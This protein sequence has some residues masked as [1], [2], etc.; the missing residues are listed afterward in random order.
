MGYIIHMTPE[1]IANN[2]QYQKWIESFGPNCLNLMVNESGEALPCTEGIYRQQRM[3]NEVCPDLFPKIF[4]HDFTGT[5]TQEVEVPSTNLTEAKPLAKY[6]MRTTKAATGNDAIGVSLEESELTERI[7]EESSLSS[8]LNDFKKKVKTLDT[9]GGEYPIVSFLGTG[10]AVPSKYRNVSGHLLQLNPT[11]SVLIDCGE[12]TYG[13]L[14]VLH[15]PDRIE[16]TLMGLS[17]IFVTHAH[18]DHIGGIMTIIERRRE[19]FESKD[20]KYK[21][22]VLACNYNVR[23]MLTMYRSNFHNLD[24]YLS[25]VEI[26]LYVTKSEDFSNYSKEDLVS[27]ITENLPK[28]LYSPESWN[29]KKVQAAQVHHTRMANGFIFD[30]NCGKR[31]VFSGD[32]MPCKLLA[33]TGKDADLL[34]HEATFE[35]GHENDA[36]RKKH[37]TIGQAIGVAKTMN[38]KHLILSHFSARYPRMTYISDLM[39]S[40]G[41]VGVAFDNMVVPF[42]KH[43]LLPLLLPVY[44]QLFKKELE[45][46][47]VKEMQRNLRFAPDESKEPRQHKK[48]KE[49]TRNSKSPVVSKKARRISDSSNIEAPIL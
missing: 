22:L 37:S 7:Q 32:T 10:S 20:V 6:P 48:S 11:T 46:L 8:I 12:G 28:D 47:S 29:L 13:Q 4:L 5:V 25:Y 1:S 34:I 39:L 23:K 38:A 30:T 14:K 15:G 45:E 31:I 3:L 42:N 18:L 9:S 19:S 26:G 35:D 16:D 41:N 33:E 44:T 24:Q 2:K 21:P 27:N 17:A 43:Q 36:H 40:S 49:I